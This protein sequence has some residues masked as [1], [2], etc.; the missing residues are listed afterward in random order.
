METNN[1]VHESKD[2]DLESGCRLSGWTSEAVGMNGRML[3]E[4]RG[5]RRGLVVAGRRSVGVTSHEYD[6]VASEVEQVF[7]YMLLLLIAIDS[8]KRR[9]TGAAGPSRSADERT[10]RRIHW[11]IRDLEVQHISQVESSP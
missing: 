10:E 3:L 8:V 9:L 1:F 11:K 2:F 7:G 6:V 4:S 5:Y